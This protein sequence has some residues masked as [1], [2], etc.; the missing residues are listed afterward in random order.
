MSR[1]YQKLRESGLFLVIDKNLETEY[2]VAPFYEFK[3]YVS[4]I[5]TEQ[6]TILE[7]RGFPIIAESEEHMIEALD[8]YANATGIQFKYFDVNLLKEKLSE[9]QHL[10]STK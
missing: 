10:E 4:N 6:S 3:V 7:V 2:L 5:G 8:L 9:D 1:L